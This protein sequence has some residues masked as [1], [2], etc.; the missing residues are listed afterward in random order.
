MIRIPGPAE[1]A[2]GDPKGDPKGGPKGDP[3]GGPPS[4]AVAPDDPSAAWP[5]PEGLIVRLAVSGG[6]VADVRLSPSARVGAAAALIGQPLPDAV[7]LVGRVFSLC[8]RAQTVAA[9]RAAEAAE[10]RAVDA[11]TEAA[12]SLLILAEAVEQGTLT[13]LLDGPAAIG[14][15]PD[16]AILRAV[17]RD[18]AEVARRAAVP[19]WD[20]VGGGGR[21]APAW[22][23][24]GLAESVGTMAARLRAVL[25]AGGRLPESRAG[26]RACLR[27]DDGTVAAVLAAAMAEPPLAEGPPRPLAGWSLDDFAPALRG[28][29]AAAFAARPTWR[30][31]PAETGP[32]AR[33][34]R[35]PLV[36]DLWACGAIVAARL[37]ARVLDLVRTVDGMIR[38]MRPPGVAGAT[39]APAVLADGRGAGL[40]GVETA[41]G[42]LLHRVAV[43]TGRVADWRIVAPTEWT[44][45]PDG[46]L[47][48]VLAGLDAT[49][50]AALRRR[51]RLLVAA[52][53][54]CVA[55]DLRLVDSETARA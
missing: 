50:A 19:G 41:R 7:R 51:V 40:S 43:R 24:P 8:G 55:C 30:G 10:G 33:F 11:A 3:E 5:D 48:R 22:P 39:A 18:A 25:P 32:L 17:R 27:E 26:L 36:R 29:G 53:D 38:L 9:A 13:L 34:A 35:H 1:G 12:R 14:Q 47:R 15:A 37:V 45:H 52:M 16:T 49:D 42:L 54:P 6:R 44:F 23:G 4:P 21:A 46:P 2:A 31:A 20:A 28:P